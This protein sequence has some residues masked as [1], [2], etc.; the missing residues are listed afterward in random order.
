LGTFGR[1]YQDW[2]ITLT[3]HMLVPIDPEFAPG[4]SGISPAAGEAHPGLDA[5]NSHTLH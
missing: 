3:A 5:N 2:W 4:I 1:H